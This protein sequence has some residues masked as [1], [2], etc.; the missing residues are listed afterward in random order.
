MF[1]KL[2]TILASA[3]ARALSL[4]L[5][6]DGTLTVLVLPSA[7]KDAVL[8]RPL[9]LTGTA[10]ELDADFESCVSSFSTK[11]L[12]LAEQMEATSAIIEAASKEAAAKA[13]KAVKKSSSKTE[14]TPN[15]DTGAGDDD[16]EDDTEDK[17]GIPVV[18]VAQKAPAAA[19]ENLWA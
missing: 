2:Q 15:S 4:T 10:S 5:N 8:N 1:S 14:S 7:N 13:V 9:D 3:G 11:R 6:D 12:T 19:D 18:T 17:T 16:D